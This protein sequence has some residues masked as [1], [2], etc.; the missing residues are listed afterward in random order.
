MVSFRYLHKYDI[1]SEVVDYGNHGLIV[2]DCF[3]LMNS[4]MIMRLM[5]KSM[6]KN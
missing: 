2:S 4:R 3:K 6:K 1:Q 5:M